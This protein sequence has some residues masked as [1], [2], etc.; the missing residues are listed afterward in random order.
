[1]II[2]INGDPHNGILIHRETNGSYVIHF[3]G[4]TKDDYELYSYGPNKKGGDMFLKGDY[5]F[6]ID[7]KI[8]T[9]LTLMNDRSVFKL[10]YTNEQ[11]GSFRR[12]SLD[13]LINIFGSTFIIV[14]KDVEHICFD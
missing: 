8:G 2:S 13:E 5:T 11:D 7:A 12:K 3:K 4:I 14:E 6:L 1:M 10:C 9:K